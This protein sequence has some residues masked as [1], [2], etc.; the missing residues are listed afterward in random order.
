MDAGL[1]GQQVSLPIVLSDEHNMRLALCTTVMPSTALV[2]TYWFVLRPRRRRER[3]EFFRRARR[4]L[5]EEKSDLLRESKETVH[6]LEDAARRH[7]Q[8][9][10]SCNG[11]VILEASYGPSERDEA[12]AGLDVDVTVP[13][14][15]LVHRSQLYI[16]GRRSKAGLQGFYDPAPGVAKTLRIRYAFCGY[17]HYAEIPDWM[18]VVLPL[19]EHRVD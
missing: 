2:F 4:T 16:P 18:P 6:L 14:Q 3:L 5:H 7:M 10:A 8:T 13:L 12:T 19:E 11:L 9:E 17:S 1:L 15:A